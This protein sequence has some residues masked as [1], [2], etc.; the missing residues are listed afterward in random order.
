MTTPV[1]SIPARVASPATAYKKPAEILADARLSED[2]KL[3]A[4][5]N[6]ESDQKALLRADDENMGAQKP[7]RPAEDLLAE[8][9]RAERKVE[10]ERLQQ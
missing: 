9:Q 5:K 2:E 7:V 10:D 6:W 3:A 1:Q 4:L 8:I